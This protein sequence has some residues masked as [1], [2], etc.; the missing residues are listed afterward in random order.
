MAQ[1]GSPAELIH[2]WIRPEIREQVAY[3]ASARSEPVKLDAMENP[4]DWPAEHKSALLE[5]LGQA[6]LNRYPDPGAV[7]LKSLMRSHFGIDGSVGLM[8][9]NGSDELLQI[10]CAALGG[11]GRTILTPAPTFAMYRLLAAASG[12]RC[13]AVPLRHD[14]FALDVEAVLQAVER[15]QPAVVFLAHPNNPT[16]NLFDTGAMAALV[17]VT[18]GI[19]VVDEAYYP[20]SGATVLPWLEKHANVFVLRTLSKMGLAGLRVGMLL[21]PHAWLDELEKLRLPYNIGCLPQMAAEY[22]LEHSSF[23]SAQV[24]QIVDG[25]RQLFDALS[26]HAD[27]RVW[28]SAANFLL[29]RVRQQARALHQELRNAG[30]LIKCLDGT[31]PLLANCLRVTVGTTEENALFLAAFGAAIT[32]G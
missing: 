5:R 4:F 19:V 14:D 16:G 20:F 21:C 12:S 23:L 3:H 29:C 1:A 6:S 32:R 2:R 13:V 18:P 28:P 22:A 10:I 24:R 15:E 26:G 27:V 8:L 17:E 7:R 9:G 25:R 31:H 30:V 11:P